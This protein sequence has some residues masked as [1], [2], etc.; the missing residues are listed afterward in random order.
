MPT[1][2]RKIYKELGNVFLARKIRQIYNMNDDGWEEAIGGD[3]PPA[4]FSLIRYQSEFGLSFSLPISSI[5][6]NSSFFFIVTQIFRSDYPVAKI[7]R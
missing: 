2:F 5:M 6:F 1:R 4:F 7:T 3:L